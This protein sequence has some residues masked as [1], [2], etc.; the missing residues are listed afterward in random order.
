LIDS[1]LSYK[2]TKLRAEARELDLST[3]KGIFISH[4]HSDHTSSA[5]H[6]ANKLGAVI[7]REDEESQ[8]A[9]VGQLMVSK[10][11]LSHDMPSVGYS[12]Y[13]TKTGKYVCQVTDTGYVSAKVANICQQACLLILESNHDEEMLLVG[14]YPEQLK[15]RIDSDLGHLSNESARYV[16]EELDRDVTEHVILAH[17]SEENNSLGKINEE[18]EDLLSIGAPM[19]HVATQVEGSSVFYI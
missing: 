15:K 16:V 1:G 17:I 10:F 5:K 8:L 19:L 4:Q 9:S 13:S 7:Y 6:I 11:D 3:V 18:F 12:V 14:G 2:Q